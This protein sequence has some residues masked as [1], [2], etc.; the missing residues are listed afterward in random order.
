M[1]EDATRR[2]NFFSWDE[3]VFG[4]SF[5]SKRSFK[6][7]KQINQRTKKDITQRRTCHDHPP[8]HQFFRFWSFFAKPDV[9]HFSKTPRDP[10]KKPTQSQNP[11][12]PSNSP[13]QQNQTNK[14][15]RPSNS[16]T[17]RVQRLLRHLLA[18]VANKTKE[19]KQLL[20]MTMKDVSIR[21]TERPTVGE[22]GKLAMLAETERRRPKRQK[23]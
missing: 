8:T 11:Q 20:A 21:P 1:I 2:R 18:S 15:T 5:L 9:W 14:A 22:R 12:N 16:T 7:K 23:G 13:F 19:A 6:Q 17:R 4:P 10:T 3:V